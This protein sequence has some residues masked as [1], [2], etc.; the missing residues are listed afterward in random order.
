VQFVL[1]VNQMRQ[2]FEPEK[3]A[4][5]GAF[6]LSSVPFPPELNPRTPGRFDLF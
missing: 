3:V 1:L 6:G 4:E 5:N 2:V